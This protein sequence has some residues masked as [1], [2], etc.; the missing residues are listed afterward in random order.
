MSTNNQQQQISLPSIPALVVRGVGEFAKRN[1]VI[2]GSYVF[3]ILFLLFIGSG[4]KLSYEQSQRYNAIMNSIDVSAEHEASNRYAQASHAYRAT[5][6]WFTCDHL[7]TR[8]KIRMDDAKAVLDSVRDEGYARMSDAKSVAG[9]FSEVGV[10]EVKDSF[11]QYFS[12]G[13]KFAKRQSMYDALFMGMR[14]MSR[15]ESMM[16]YV[17]KMLI[18]FLLNMSMGMIGALFVFIMGLL[19][20]IRSYQPNPIV[21]VIFFLGS[22]CAAFAFVSTYLFAVFGAAAGGVY[23][24]AQV[25]VSRAQIEQQQNRRRQNVGYHPHQH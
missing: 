13:K 2:S 25:A 3:G 15:D 12:S 7:C 18:Q 20:I 14:S 5:K 9:L 17:M 23:G 21:A 16:E 22:A 1:K 4:S 19:S 11:W 8:N 10:G 6:G 24:L